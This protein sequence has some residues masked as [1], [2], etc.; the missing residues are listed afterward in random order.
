MFP[1]SRWAALLSRNRSSTNSA[2]REPF[3]SSAGGRTP[4][5]WQ[6]RAR[7]RHR[8]EATPGGAASLQ[9]SFRSGCI[10]LAPHPGPLPAPTLAL[11]RERGGSGR[12]SERGEGPADPRNK[13]GEEPPDVGLQ[14]TDLVR[15]RPPGRA[16][17]GEGQQAQG[18][19]RPEAAHRHLGRQPAISWTISRISRRR[20]TR[21]PQTRSKSATSRAIRSGATALRA[22]STSANS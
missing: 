3:G 22:P 1:A 12:A 2:C 7:D 19:A 15:G 17:R 6:R 18:F 5:R 21:L 13:S 14:P 9:S 20:G 10:G 16:F 8:T 11:P 4:K